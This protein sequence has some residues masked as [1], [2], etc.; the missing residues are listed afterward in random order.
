M[1]N[2][3][4]MHCDL[5][6]FIVALLILTAVGCTPNIQQKSPVYTH[7]LLE[8]GRY[9]EAIQLL[10]QRMNEW[11]IREKEIGHSFEGA[12]G[13]EYHKVMQ[14]IAE[15][16][17]RDWGRILEDPEIPYEYKTDLIFEI[18]ESKLGKG[19]IYLGNSNNWIVPRYA[20]ID[21]NTQM[22]S[23]PESEDRQ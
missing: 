22:I 3:S 1:Q 15:K 8:Q 13:F 18:L 14:M 5:L 9:L 20:P 7:D 21:L 11:H 16:G 6:Q 17:A 10:P 2:I 19:A 23:F 12:A 4:F